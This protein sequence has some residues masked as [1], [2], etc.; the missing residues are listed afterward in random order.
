MTNR[1]PLDRG[2]VL[3]VR[4]P[5]TDLSAQKRR[6]ALVIGRPSGDDL[7]LAFVT[8]NITVID[9]QA[10]HLL[11][12]DDPEFRRTGLKTASLVRLNRIAT[13]HRSLVQRR[14]GHIGPQTLQAIGRRLRHV[15]AL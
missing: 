1:P 3:L 7:V 2:D 5:F 14:L 13:L 9:A 15:F 6:P 8:S 10:E 12:P 11:R 4:F